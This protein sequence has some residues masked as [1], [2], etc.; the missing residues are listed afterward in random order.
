MLASTETT[1]AKSKLCM[2]KVMQEGRSDCRPYIV[3]GERERERGGGPEQQAALSISATSSG[4]EE[5][6]TPCRLR[7]EWVE[8]TL[9]LNATGL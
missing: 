3:A 9:Y 4:I 5:N 7:E 8:Y 2:T 1:M 6:R